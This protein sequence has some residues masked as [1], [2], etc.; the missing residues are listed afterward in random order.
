MLIGLQT[1]GLQVGPIH[2]RQLIHRID[3]FVL[4]SKLYY[5]IFDVYEGGEFDT[6]KK[7]LWFLELKEFE[8]ILL[9]SIGK[10]IILE[11]EY[12]PFS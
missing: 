5:Y 12:T 3:N 8:Q 2:F 11:V 9:Q 4:I 6:V 1:K 10:Q 7:P